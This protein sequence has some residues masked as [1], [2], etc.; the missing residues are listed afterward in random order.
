M[1]LAT[2]DVLN[3]IV[4]DCKLVCQD[5]N[6]NFKPGCGDSDLTLVIKLLG[7]HVFAFR[8]V[9]L[10]KRNMVKDSEAYS[11]SFYILTKL[12]PH[13]AAAYTRTEYHNR[14]IISAVISLALVYAFGKGE[15]LTDM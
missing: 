11:F 14:N 10:K 2:D 3:K 15:T 13:L 6:W 4:A 5:W 12:F 9:M 8:A 1:Y 7:A